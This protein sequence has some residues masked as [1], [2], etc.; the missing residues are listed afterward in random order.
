MNFHLVF[1]TALT[2]LPLG[3]CSSIIPCSQFSAKEIRT[4]ATKAT[5]H[6]SGPSFTSH[7]VDSPVMKLS[8][9]LLSRNSHKPLGCCCQRPAPPLSLSMPFLS[10]ATGP[11]QPSVSLPT[12]VLRFSLLLLWHVCNLDCIWGKGRVRTM[13]AVRDIMRN[14]LMR[15][16]PLR[17][18]HAVC[19]PQS[20][21]PHR[22]S[23][24]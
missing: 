2:A 19:S 3:T 11:C 10:F 4:P 5:P 9:P 8:T 13:G 12:L 18:S 6:S 22:P 1:D 23:P 24:S 15:R 16:L 17:G 20:K 21:A 7:A 14:A